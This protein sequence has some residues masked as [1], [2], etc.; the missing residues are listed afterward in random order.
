VGG[1]RGTTSRRYG[2]AVRFQAAGH[3]GASTPRKEASVTGHRVRV[4]WAGLLVMLLGG[5]CGGLDTGTDTGTA[6]GQVDTLEVPVTAFSAIEAGSAFRVNLSFGAK[7]SLVLRVGE[8][9]A[10]RVEAT[11]AAGVLRLR[12]EPGTVARN[13]RLE[14]D[15]TAQRLSQI[16]LSGAA[17]MRVSG[18]VAAPTLAVTASGASQLDGPLRVTEGSATLSGASRMALSGDVERLELRASG[19]SRV[20]AEQLRVDELDVRLSGA[21]SASVSVNGSVAA[22]VSGASSLRYGG[23][24]R[25][26]RRD[27][28]G[29]SSITA[30]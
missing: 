1:I 27:V 18:E 11:V 9:V 29:A 30:L 28:S 4:V 17:V 20:D 26:V 22:Q 8:E 7:E 16:G 5:A 12:L 25:F 6:T 21:S 2:D 15:V 10:D 23:S 13:A 19:A 24:P 3:T 14:A